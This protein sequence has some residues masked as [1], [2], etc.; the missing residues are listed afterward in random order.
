MKVKKIINNNVALID[1]GGNEA[2]IYMTGI[3]FKKKVGQRINDSEIEKTYVLD[4]KDRLE[5]FS[6]LLSHSDDRLISMINELVSYGEKEIGK[7]ANDYLYLALLDH[8]SFAL[9]RSEKGQ[10]LRSPLF[11]EVKKFYPVYYK[12]G[13][14]AL[15]MMKKYFNNSF[16]TDEAV[17]IAL[18]FVNLQENQVNFDEQIEDMETLRDMLN[19]I[20]YHFSLSIDEE[21]INY[22]RLVTHLQY[23]IERLRKKQA[24][25]ENE[26]QLFEQ[27]KKLYPKAYTA[28]EKIEIYVKG[29]FNTYLSQDEYT[30]L[31]IHVNRVAERGDNNG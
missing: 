30:Y 25:V 7:K 11:W 27:V 29:K 10:Y 15:K 12:I 14:E 20:K 18:H 19:I 17:S 13:L 23:F 22:M 24:Y 5:H 8:L 6:Y 1:R 28:V 16:P 3:A 26:S 31:M 2:I 9:K 21:S 4:S